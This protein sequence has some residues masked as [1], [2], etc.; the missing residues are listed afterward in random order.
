MA[1]ITPKGL[2]PRGFNRPPSAIYG[3]NQE[4][5]SGSWPVSGGNPYE[6]ID[7]ISDISL[8]ETII[9]EPKNKYGM[10]IRDFVVSGLSNGA[11]LK[12]VLE[13]DSETII[14]HSAQSGS[15]VSILETELEN[16][17]PMFVYENL[18]LFLEQAGETNAN[19]RIQQLSVR[20]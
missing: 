13:I 4:I 3:S 17:P 16:L 8:G 9:I 20:G 12:L 14:D 10:L 11:N 15:S 6:S 5:K 19:I 18:S 1:I 2:N 7:I